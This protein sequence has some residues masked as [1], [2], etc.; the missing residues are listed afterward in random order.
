MKVII[1]RIPEEGLSLTFDE[2]P[3]S[4]PVLTEIE[5]S[6]ECVFIAPIH[7]EFEV[8]RIRDLI[9]VK[10]TVETRVRIPCARCLEEY[11]LPVRKP[12][13]VHYTQN[14]P[15]LEGPATKDVVE[16]RDELIGLVPFEGD[17]IE[18]DDVIQE[19]VVV[20]LP[21]RPL[22]R[23]DCKGLCPRCGADRNREP[24]DCDTARRDERFAVLKD[25]KLK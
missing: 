16:I 22:C 24:C 12:L 21:T 17:A 10:G 2:K 23:A 8:A 14:M 25:L 20:S 6:G 9:S 19:Q 4:F 7:N 15:E 18:L 13:N 5:A 1:D 3:K 11:E